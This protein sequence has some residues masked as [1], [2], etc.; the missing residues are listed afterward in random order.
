MSINEETLFNENKETVKTSSDFK[1]EVLFKPVMADELPYQEP[2]VKDESKGFDVLFKKDDGLREESLNPFITPVEIREN[3][4][5]ETEVLYKSGVEDIEVVDDD[6]I[7]EESLTFSEP[8][9]PDYVSEEVLFNKQEELAPA[10]D[11]G[12]FS[13]PLIGGADEELTQIS[14][15]DLEAISNRVD[16][17]F[18][19]LTI[20][21]EPKK[22]FAM[23]MLEA[24]PT[25][26]ERYQELK[27]ILLIYKKV[28]SRIS[29]SCD[30]FN[31]GR[32]KL[33]K[34]TIAGKTLKLYLNLNLDEAESR[35]RCKDASDKKSYEEVPVL[36][37]IRSDRS[38]KYAKELLIQLANKHQLVENPKSVLVDAVALLKEKFEK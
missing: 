14:F 15:G 33:A 12:I 34:I 31:F 17:N 19:K 36:L 37:K 22:P 9:R 35:F 26:L 24:E 2:A 23:K 29:N 3:T 28:K 27:N 13:E 38:M 5:I 6:I 4:A 10:V 25:T 1:E 30:T 20:N 32:T 21:R 18:N 8:V 11:I 16:D 7:A